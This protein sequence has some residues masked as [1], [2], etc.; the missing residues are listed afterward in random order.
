[1][2]KRGIVLLLAVS[3]LFSSIPVTAK[4]N[5]IA[6]SAEN[7]H[8]AEKS[9][10]AGE[11][12]KTMAVG[13]NVLKYEVEGNSYISLNLQTGELVIHNKRSMADYSMDNL[14]AW[15]AYKNKITTVRVDG[16]LKKIGD[17]AFYDCASLKEVYF[18]SDL[19]E[20]GEGAFAECGKIKSIKLPEK[21][22]CIDSYAFYNCSS[23]Q[24]AEFSGN[25][26]TDIESHAFAM[27]GQLESALLPES[28]NVIE[29]NAFLKC[30][31][32]QKVFTDNSRIKRIEFGAFAYCASL[33][34]ITL[35]S[36]EEIGA[37]AFYK[38]SALT[39]VSFPK[40]KAIEEYAFYGCGSLKKA[41]ITN[42]EYI[43][44][45]A[46]AEVSQLSAI[47]FGSKITTVG[48]AAFENC[49]SLSMVSFAPKGTL[50]EIQSY[51]FHNCTALQEIRIPESTEKIGDGVFI[52]CYRLK[53]IEVYSTK[54]RL[55]NNV[56]KDL[57]VTMYFYSGAQGI[58]DAKNQG[59]HYEYFV[60]ISTNDIVI[61]YKNDWIYTGKQIK[62]A[63]VVKYKGQVLQNGKDYTV[64]Y[65]ENIFGTGKIILYGRGS[66]CGQVEKSFQ[67]V[68]AEQ[69]IVAPKS[70]SKTLVD[71]NFYIKL[72]GIKERAVINYSIQ[73]SKIAVC[74]KYGKVSLK[75]KEGNTFIVIT[76]KDTAHYR[77]KTI[78]IP[79]NVKKAEQEIEV[80]N[81]SYVK[82][83]TDK[84][85]KLNVKTKGNAKVTYS[86]SDKKIATCDKYGKVKLKGKTGKVTITVKA[87]STSKYTA[88][89]KKI[90]IKVKKLPTVK[91]KAYK[92]KRGFKLSWG[93][94]KN[95]KTVKYCFKVK[96]WSKKWHK[97][98]SKRSYQFAGG[99]IKSNLWVKIRV[100]DKNG[101]LIAASKAVKAK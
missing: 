30:V 4:E 99:R 57:N 26:L 23:L 79:L 98:Y 46:F 73:N 67:I 32:L 22:R 48:V 45:Y 63:V 88:D 51:A 24:R 86:V 78:K 91:L 36:V 81:F 34:N 27:C 69:N 15:H 1:M 16:S 39:S 52:G 66:Y 60:M 5:S 94:V 41:E 31:S 68:K 101:R 43:G 96:K 70:Y 55:G 62:P 54:A 89:S 49:Y 65:G 84:P 38:C 9:E 82:Y 85:W 77:G 21:L 90:T 6:E 8:I 74:D 19:D 80:K 40:I 18:N 50:K 47:S 20:I 25:I 97:T 11:L 75:G 76:V 61:S 37:S 58:N 14:P 56:C 95:A 7:I 64:S 42:T 92:T 35:K 13:T 44:D 71:R 17:Y 12:S 3:I 10:S 87:K 93:N 2:Q 59:I 53:M 83:V 100:Y 29:D 28:V 72:S 33:L